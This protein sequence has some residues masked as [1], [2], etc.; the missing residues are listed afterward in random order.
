VYVLQPNIKKAYYSLYTFYEIIP[1]NINRIL[2]I[3]K[4]A[5]KVVFK[6]NLKKKKL[7]NGEFFKIKIASILRHNISEYL[8]YRNIIKFLNNVDYT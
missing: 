8:C 4:K 3:L 7:S 2:Y 1:C 5:L 6:K